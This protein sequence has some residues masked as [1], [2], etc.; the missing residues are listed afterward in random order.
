MMIVAGIDV[1]SKQLHMVVLKG[2]KPSNVLIFDNTPEGFSSLWNALR[3]RKVKRVV[4]EATGV[5]HLDVSLMLARKKIELMVLNPSAANHYGKVR[6]IRTKTDKVDAGVLAEFAQHMPFEPWQAPADEVLAVR[7]CARRL[8]ALT[9]MRAQ[10]KNQLHAVSH[11][12]STPGFIVDDVQL[13]IEQINLQIDSLEAK[14]IALISQ[15]STAQRSFEQLMSV[16]GI[17]EKSA[18][19]LLGELL[20]LPADMR[21][22]QWVAMAGLD[23]RHHESGSSV[24]KKTRISKVGNRYLRMALYMPALSASRHVPEVR[25]YYLHLIEDKGLK[26]IQAICAVMRKLLLAIHGMWA[27]DTLFDASRFYAVKPTA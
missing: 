27:R 14:T 2:K 11:T 6:M 5:Y 8:A 13:T 23:P 26:K 18:I 24:S 1:G 4:L 9:R 16:K 25:A 3:K 21:G 15:D 12:N 20:V 10:A 17:A 7:A 19:Q 22:K